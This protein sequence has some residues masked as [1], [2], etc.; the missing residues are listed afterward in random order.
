MFHSSKIRIS[1]IRYE[2]TDKG[3]DY[4]RCAIKSVELLNILHMSLPDNMI[5]R[6]ETRM[7]AHMIQ[8]NPP[9]VTLNVSNNN[10]DADCAILLAESLK[11]NDRLKILNL[12]KNK[13]GDKG[14]MELLKP[15]IK[16]KFEL[17]VVQKTAVIVD[18]STIPDD[19]EQVE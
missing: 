8:Q 10:L 19:K 6:T 5:S 11:F 14:I 9:L 4:I 12:D 2:L 15:L 13:L 18:N 7:L 16:Q 17:F 3:P 1:K